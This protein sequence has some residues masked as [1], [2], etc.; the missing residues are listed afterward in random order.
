[1]KKQSAIPVS[2]SSGNVFT[3]LGLPNAAELS[4]KAELTRQL[5]HRIQDLGLN[6]VQAAKRLGLSQ[7]DVSR[8][9]HGRHTG[10]SGDRLL[11][12]LNSLA[13]DVEIILRPQAR[14]AGHQGKIRV[15]AAA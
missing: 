9:L 14:P 15:L 12:L 8:L 5:Y 1:M 6:Q 2:E 3:D 10:F 11:G 13:V 4:L 7:A